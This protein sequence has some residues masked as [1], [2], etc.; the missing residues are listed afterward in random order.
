[1][2]VRQILYPT[3]FSPLAGSA[4]PLALR[5]A[6]AFAAPLHLLHALSPQGLTASPGDAGERAAEHALAQLRELAAVA[7]EAGAQVVIT[8]RRVDTT[9]GI[10]DYVD[11]AAIDLVVM[12]THG[13]S[14]PPRWLFG[15]VAEEILRRGACA[16][17]TVRADESGPA[18]DTVTGLERILVPFDSSPFSRAALIAAADVARRSGGRLKLLH[19][20]E[21][22]PVVEA[23]GVAVTDESRPAQECR[24]H[25]ARLRLCDLLGYLANGILGEVVVRVGEPGSEILRMAN[26]GGVD[27]VVL[28]SHGVAGIKRVLFGSTAEEVLRGAVPPVMVVP[29]ALVEGAGRA[30][31]PDRHV[32]VLSGGVEPPVRKKLVFE[33]MEHEPRVATAGMSLDRA[34]ALMSESAHGYLP[35]VSGLC[36]VVGILTRH[37]VA[38]ARAAHDGGPSGLTVR[39]AMCGKP[40]TCRLDDDIATALAVM[41]EHRV[42]RL[43][44]VDSEGQLVGIVGQEG[45]A[46]AARVAADGTPAA[47]GTAAVCACG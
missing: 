30:A 23:D 16:L 31:A 17:L 40:W 13:R 37:D 2:D 19:V 45:L 47:N 11:E 14:G 39:D 7:E 25:Q 36:H 20:L 29:P 27:L 33:V 28:G 12:A 26:S 22:T 1:M 38:A 18:A 42:R 9:Q 10:L 15:S 3:D 35:V 6:Q 21:E 34:A 5:C 44:V 8:Q 46:H 32:G 24:I 43:P 41:I 4:F